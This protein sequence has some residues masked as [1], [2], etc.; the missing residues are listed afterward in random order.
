MPY[1]IG[2]FAEIVQL[3]M[4]TLRYYEKEHLI[5]VERDASGRRA[6]T[7]ADIRWVGFIKRLK[8]TGMPIREI[9]EYALLRDQGDAT[10]RERLQ[11]LEKHRAF[12]LAEQ[13]KWDANLSHLETKIK[14]YQ[15]QIEQM[16]HSA[17][18]E[19]R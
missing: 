10:L 19:K 1:S 13:A 2:R 9:R 3:H 17:E 16:K 8:E 12:V 14:T 5:R 11:M 7:D 6:Y 18:K 4:D 15:E